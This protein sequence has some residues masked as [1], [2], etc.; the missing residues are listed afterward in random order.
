M[1]FKCLPELPDDIKV[2]K[3]LFKKKKI[4]LISSKMVEVRLYE[5][6]DYLAW[7]FETDKDY[8]VEYLRDLIKS[9]EPTSYMTGSLEEA[10][11]FDGVRRY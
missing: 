8:D 10:E 11:N 1:K 3:R 2:V 5:L 9:V 7:E 6:C 4:S